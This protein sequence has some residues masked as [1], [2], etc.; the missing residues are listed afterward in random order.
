MKW[1]LPLNGLQSAATQKAMLRPLHFVPHDN[2]IKELSSANSFCND[3]MKV[4]MM[5]RRRGTDV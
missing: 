3:G 1:N 4:M 2:M 5:G